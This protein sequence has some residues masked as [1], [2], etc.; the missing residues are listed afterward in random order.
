MN[1]SVYFYNYKGKQYQLRRYFHSKVVR[2]YV[3]DNQEKKHY[4]GKRI[5]KAEKETYGDLFPK[6]VKYAP[7]YIKIS[8]F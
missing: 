4:Q 7:E 8:T 1:E 2:F 6:F 3:I 5:V